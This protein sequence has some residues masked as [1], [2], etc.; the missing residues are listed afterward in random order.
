MDFD[1]LERIVAEEVKK[2]LAEQTRGDETLL[3]PSQNETLDASACKGP[4]CTVSASPFQTPGKSNTFSPD[5]TA[6]LVLFTGAREKWDVL[7]NA[8][9]GWIDAGIRLDAVFSPSARYIIPVEELTSMGFRMI[10]QPSEINE[11]MY[12]MKRYAATFVPSVSRTH[13]A[14]LAL[15]ITDSVTLNLMLASLAHKVPTIASDDGLAPTA[16][17][18]CGNHVPGIQ[19]I[20][21]KYRDQLATMGMKLNPAEEAVRDVQNI[22][23]NKVESGP[24][25][26]TSLITE[27][28]AVKLKGPVVKVSRGGL[29]TPLAMEYFNRQGIE[30][31][32]V[33][34]K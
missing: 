30:V 18:V 34:Q 25:L 5:Q 22:V 9:K 15:A 31:V 8:F 27:D 21:A 20:L 11:I 24:D 17:V 28:D 12:D 14:K 1:Q 4:S 33:P 19:E 3:P 16:C 2:V 10:D 32:I 7:T 6:I 29:I 23:F 26:I 13:A